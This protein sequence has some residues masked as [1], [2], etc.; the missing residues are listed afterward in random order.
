MAAKT[1]RVATTAGSRRGGRRA[2]AS[3]NAAAF[4]AKVRMYRQ[5]L[6]DCVLITLPL[7]NPR[8]NRGNFYIMV[9]CGVILGTPDAADTMAKVVEDLVRETDGRIDLL[10]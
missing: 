9:D 4:R 1:A 5:C 8:P 10:L 3:P 2:P 6:G 7:K